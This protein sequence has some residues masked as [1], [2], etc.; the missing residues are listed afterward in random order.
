[1]HV[2]LLMTV[3]TLTLTGN[4]AH[5]AELEQSFPSNVTKFIKDRESC[6]H[7]RGE[8]R[9]FDESYKREFGKEAESE[10]IERATFL[11]KMTEKTCFKIDE[12]LRLLKWKYRSNKLIAN[13]LNVYGYVD[14][15]SGYIYIHKDFPNAASIMATLIA[16]G[17][18]PSNVELL[19][20]GNWRGRLGDRP[21]PEKLTIQI[22]SI[23]DVF[24]AQLAI[25]TLLEYGFKDIGVVL[26]PKEYMGLGLSVLIGSHP[27][28][29]SYVYT[30]K[31]IQNLLKPGL[32]EHAFRKF[33]EISKPSGDCT[34]E[35]M[36][37]VNGKSK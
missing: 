37:C 18:S 34:K 32:S 6:D 19:K 9:D 31:G 8:P 5:C 35:M 26:L 21:L 4:V 2:K 36:V 29:N 30:G 23:V 7:F 25:E 12:R 10:E 15:G 22:G 17:F 20:G 24:P 33:S 28:G 13:M 11:D 27:L 16:K 3:I 1:M 14:I